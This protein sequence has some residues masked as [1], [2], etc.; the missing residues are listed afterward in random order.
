M[1]DLPWRRS[2]RKMVEGRQAWVAR[3]QDETWRIDPPIG[4]LGVWWHLSVRCPAGSVGVMS[5]PDVG[6]LK[7]LA[8]QWAGK[9][10]QIVMSNSP[11]PIGRAE[12]EA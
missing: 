5:G 1:V 4:V 7:A 12:V 8:D 2:P 11:F 3:H 6:E 10:R 9:A